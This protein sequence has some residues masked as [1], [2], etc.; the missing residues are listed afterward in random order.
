NRRRNG[1]GQTRFMLQVIPMEAPQ[2]VITAGFPFVIHSRD[3]SLVTA[4]NPA[5]AGETLRLFVSGLGPTKPPVDPGQPF[6]VSP[7][8]AVTSPVDVTVNGKSATV[9]AA[10]GLP[11]AVDRYQID[12]SMPPDTD[13]G[14]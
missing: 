11:G 14:I 2:V 13:K 6:P 4:Y 9:L 5:A 3:S 1:G 8:A 10:V 7:P 12:V